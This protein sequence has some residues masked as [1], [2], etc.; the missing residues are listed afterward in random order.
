MKKV[1]F[2]SIVRKTNAAKSTLL[3][4]IMHQKI[5]IATS[6]PQTTRNSI[7]GIYSDE[8]SQIV[9]IDTPGVVKT[10]QKLDRY[11]NKQISY[12]LIDID[13]LIILVDAGVPFNKDTDEALKSR[14]SKDIPTFV[15]FNKIDLTNIY[16]IENL[17]KQYQELF[18]EAKIIEISC[19]NNFNIDYL[20]S[21]IKDVLPD[22]EAYY[23]E[24]MKSNHPISFLIGEIIREKILLYTSQEVPHCAAVK[25]DSMK[26]INDTLHID[27]TILVEKNSQKMIIVGKGGSMIKK[28]GMASR[29]EIEKLLSRKVNLSTFVRVEEKWRDSSLYLKEFGYSESDE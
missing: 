19:K 10:H 1:G 28:I 5:S 15:V 25:I 21:Q 12:S 24:D 3:N 16:L 27:A 23:P 6:K 9:F 14:F 4:I 17:K 22:G 29:K 7:Q 8:D 20:M 18:P 26:K 11:M 2:V 13:A